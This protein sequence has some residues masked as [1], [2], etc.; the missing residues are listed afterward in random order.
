M[1][2]RRGEARNG[3]DIDHLLGGNMRRLAVIGT[4]L[5][6]LVAG[7]GGLSAPAQ[8]TGTADRLG[9]APGAA[10]THP[11]RKVTHV[12]VLITTPDGHVMALYTTVIYCNLRETD[13]D[14][15]EFHANTTSHHHAT[16]HVRKGKWTEVWFNA[17]HRFRMRVFTNG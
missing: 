14:F 12:R 10:V 6:G 8:A 15:G 2:G 11:A 1:P 13:C 3:A 4:L 17:D 5:T 9:T 7:I 16:I